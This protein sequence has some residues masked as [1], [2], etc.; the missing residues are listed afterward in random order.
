MNQAA[1]NTQQME[2]PIAFYSDTRLRVLYY[3]VTRYN[4]A[5]NKNPFKGFGD[6]KKNFYKYRARS[7]WLFQIQKDKLEYFALIDD[8]LMQVECSFKCIDFMSVSFNEPDLFNDYFRIT[9]TV[10]KRRIKD[11]HVI[12]LCNRI[13]E[14]L[15]NHDFIRRS[16]H[17]WLDF[18]SGY[19]YAEDK[20][21]IRITK[22]IESKIRERV[23]GNPIKGVTSIINRD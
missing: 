3:F 14:T 15:L 18:N 8:F 5:E 13:L 12:D 17:H 1:S 11:P 10:S 6:F 23:Q 21:E 9:I 19:H 4:T 7:P 20:D 2:Q 16:V 22:I